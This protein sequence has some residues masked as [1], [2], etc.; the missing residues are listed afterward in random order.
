[1]T[2]AARTDRSAVTGSYDLMGVNGSVLPAPVDE[3]STDADEG[4]HCRILAGEL[5]L[6]GD[7]TYRLALT[8]RYEAGSR[9]AYTRVLESG[10]TW[11]FLASALDERSGEVTLLSANG[12]V[13]SAAVTRLSLVH[14]TRVPSGGAEAT[15][16]ELTW[17]YLRRPGAA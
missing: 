1:M 16:A 15:G 12:P 7:G 4:V 5:R 14:R 6:E 10:G 8:A 2:P 3:G 17:V 11:R 13:T 9:T